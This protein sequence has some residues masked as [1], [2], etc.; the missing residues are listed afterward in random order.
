M[1]RIKNMKMNN[2]LPQN[3]PPPRNFRIGAAAGIQREACLFLAKDNSEKE[4]RLMPFVCHLKWCAED[5][6]NLIKSA[7]FT[8][9]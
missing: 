7:L 5:W 8:V 3:S 1:V 9:G 2:K 6:V 4:A